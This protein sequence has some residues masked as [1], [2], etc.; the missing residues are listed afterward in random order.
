MKRSTPPRLPMNQRRWL[1]RWGSVDLCAM[2]GIPQPEIIRMRV[3]DTF[4]NEPVSFWP[5]WRGEGGFA[6]SVV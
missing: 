6:R 1:E 2:T 4:T 5:T 3:R